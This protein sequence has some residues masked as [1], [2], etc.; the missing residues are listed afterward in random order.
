MK[1][2][3]NETEYNV[4]SGEA[5]YLTITF[6]NGQDGDSSFRDVEG[7]YHTG[8]IINIKIGTGAKLEGTFI[9]IG[10]L[11]TDTNPD[12]NTTSISYYI[13]GEEVETYS[14]DVEEDN[15][16]I[17]YTTFIKFI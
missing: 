2:I 11:V 16:A 5:Y 8:S 1:N 17:Y 12:T 10:S 9:L 15:S 14:E 7:Q 3:V 13:N 6:G 4:D